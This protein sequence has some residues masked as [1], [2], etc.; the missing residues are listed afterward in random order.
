[1]RK[2]ACKQNGLTM[3]VCDGYYDWIGDC[4]SH[5]DSSHKAAIA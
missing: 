3:Q 5:S 2:Y 4:R 1:M